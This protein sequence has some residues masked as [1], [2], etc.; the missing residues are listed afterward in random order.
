MPFNWCAGPSTGNESGLLDP[1]MSGDIRRVEIKP[2]L[3]SS[4]PSVP[5]HGSTSSVNYSV[6]F[7]GG[8]GQTLSA[9]IL[10][11][12]GKFHAVLPH[13]AS[14]RHQ[15]FMHGPFAPTGFLNGTL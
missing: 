9:T 10:F 5:Q 1:A 12:K 3:S 2:I 8:V 13:Q 4:K 14:Q 6:A 15:H 11:Q 7:Q